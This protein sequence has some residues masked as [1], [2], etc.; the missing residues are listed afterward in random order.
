M[1]NSTIDIMAPGIDRDTGY[2]II[3]A[4]PAVNNALG[5]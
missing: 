1:L 2:G 3:M 4:Q 5:H